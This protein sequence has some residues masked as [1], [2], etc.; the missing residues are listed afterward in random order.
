M[1]RSLP[2]RHGHVGSAVRTEKAMQV[3]SCRVR[4]ADHKVVT[5]EKTQ[6]SAQ[7]TLRGLGHA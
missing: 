1:G 4:C 3:E 2:R 5:V 6:W 7:R